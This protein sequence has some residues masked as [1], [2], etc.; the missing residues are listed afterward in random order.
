MS[1]TNEEGMMPV[2][3][4][5]IPEGLLPTL[6]W[7]PRTEDMA[8]RIADIIV[9]KHFLVRYD[10]MSAP[11]IAI[12]ALRNPNFCQEDI[13]RQLDNLSDGEYIVL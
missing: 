12:A 2:N 9:E 4:F 11:M 13:Q 8:N 7:L 3:F 10:E 6:P 5:E 1:R